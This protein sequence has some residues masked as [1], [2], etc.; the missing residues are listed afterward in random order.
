MDTKIQRFGFD[1]LNEKEIIGSVQTAIDSSNYAIANL[2]NQESYRGIQ[3]KIDHFVSCLQN[4]IVTAILGHAE[5][6]YHVKNDFDASI[7]DF[8]KS[9]MVILE[10]AVKSKKE[11]KH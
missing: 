10:D 3:F 6:F 8:I 4:L 1:G 9:H 2:L 7:D 11:G 5:D